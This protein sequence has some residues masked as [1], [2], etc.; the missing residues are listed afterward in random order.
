MRRRFLAHGRGGSGPIPKS[1]MAWLLS[2]MLLVII[3]LNLA[4]S[5]A[6]NQWNRSIFDALEKKEAATVSQPVDGLLRHPGHQRRLFGCPGLRADDPSA[7]L[8]QMAHRHADRPLA[9][10]RPLLSAQPGKRRSPE[11][12]ISHRRR[13]AGRDRLAGRLRHR[14]H[15]GVPVGR[16]LHRRAVDHRRRAEHHASAESEFYIPGLPGH[17]GGALRRDR[18]RRG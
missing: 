9:Q 7:A 16:Y 13:R 14:C 3:L 1:H 10:V 4:A 12:G 18:Q 5:Y 8:A 2:G 6:M 15:H 17:R 11:S